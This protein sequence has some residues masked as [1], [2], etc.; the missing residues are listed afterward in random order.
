MWKR[1]LF[2]SFDSPFNT[3][4]IRIQPKRCGSA[5]LLLKEFSLAVEDVF[6]I[7]SLVLFYC[8][9]WAPRLQMVWI[10][11][12]LSSSIYSSRVVDPDPHGPHSFS[13]LTKFQGLT[14]VLWIRN[15]LFRIRIQL[16]IFR[17]PDLDPNK[18]S[19]S[20]RIRIQPILIKTKKT[21]NSIKKKN[22]SNN[23][24]FSI[25]YFCPIVQTIRI[26]QFYLNAL[27]LF[28]GSGSWTIISDPDPGKSSGSMRIWIQI[29]NTAIK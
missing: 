8:F 21:L 12:L 29:H 14:A 13:L 17:V 3:Y 1:L 25:Q 27:S 4:W 26:L 9:A 20:M 5:T 2:S 24:P 6:F 7:R 15:D 28:A 22:L 18:S 11:A 23:L 16:W 10:R 19:G